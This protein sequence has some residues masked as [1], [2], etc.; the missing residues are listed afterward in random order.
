MTAADETPDERALRRLSGVVEGEARRALSEQQ[1]AG[2]PVLIAQGWERRFITD[3]R[4]AEE[5]VDLYRSLG[6]DVRVEPVEA[7]EVG[8]DCGDCQL[9][10][11]QF[12]M[13]YTRDAR[14]PGTSDAEGDR[15]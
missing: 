2:D 8:D 12:C 14:H 10:R 7:E 13:V 11:F 9:L 1:I 3:R 5:V 15:P 4:R 6:K